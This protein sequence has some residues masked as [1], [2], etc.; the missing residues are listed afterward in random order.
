MCALTVTSSSSQGSPWRRSLLC[1]CDRDWQATL[2]GAT[3]LHMASQ[4]DHLEAVQALL[5]GGA[6]ANVTKVLYYSLQHQVA[7]LSRYYQGLSD[8]V[9]LPSL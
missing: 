1:L 2:I 9:K 5:N 8:N 7:S 6:S 3:A 4:H